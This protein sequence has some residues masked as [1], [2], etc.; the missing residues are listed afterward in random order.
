MPDP[1][2]DIFEYGS[3]S[4]EEDDYYVAEHRSPRSTV[5]EGRRVEVRDWRRREKY[6]VRWAEAIIRKAKG[7][8]YKD[9][10]EWTACFP[11]TFH[12]TPTIRMK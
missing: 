12:I 9:T 7:V 10:T 1:T 6:L 2:E 11:G 8:R 3:S 4:D 5:I